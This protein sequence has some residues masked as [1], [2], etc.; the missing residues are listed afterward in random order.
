MLVGEDG[1]AVLSDFGLAEAINVRSA[2]KRGQGTTTYMYA[3][4]PS[5]LFL[6]FILFIVYLYCLLFFRVLSCSKCAKHEAAVATC[7]ALDTSIYTWP[8]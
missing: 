2:S 3:T 7:I 4:L 1:N 6:L 5:C 8:V